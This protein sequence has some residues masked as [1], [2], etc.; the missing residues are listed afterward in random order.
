MIISRLGHRDGYYIFGMSLYTI[1]EM[2]FIESVGRK[3]L[4]TYILYKNDGLNVMTIVF[5][6]TNR[7]IIV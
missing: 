3:H 4:C 7:Q 5:P 2:Y 1:L 6:T